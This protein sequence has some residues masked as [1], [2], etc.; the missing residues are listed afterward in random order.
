MGVTLPAGTGVAL[1]GGTV[2]GGGGA[3]VVHPAM[4]VIAVS[5]TRTLHSGTLFMIFHLPELFF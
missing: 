3:G 5:T 2:P 4:T 1:A